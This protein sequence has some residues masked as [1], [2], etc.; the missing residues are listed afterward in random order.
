MP[1]T[2]PT[3]SAQAGVGQQHVRLP[4]PIKDARK[5]AVSLVGLAGAL[6][7]VVFS[8]V[9]RYG[10][11]QLVFSMLMEDVEIGSLRVVAWIVAPVL[12]E[13]AKLS[14]VYA[15][16]LAIGIILAETAT[17][18]LVIQLVTSSRQLR[19]ITVQQRNEVLDAPES[20]IALA[21]WNLRWRI[22]AASVALAALLPVTVGTIC[23]EWHV[24][25]MRCVLNTVQLEQ[26]ADLAGDFSGTVALSYVPRIQEI[27]HPEWFLPAGEA[28]AADYG[29]LPLGIQVSAWGEVLALGLIP[30]LFLALAFHVVR[31]RGEELGRSMRQI[32]SS[33]R[34]QARR[35]WEDTGG[36]DEDDWDDEEYDESEDYAGSELDEEFPGSGHEEHDHTP[37]WECPPGDGADGDEPPISWNDDGT[38]AFCH[39]GSVLK[40]EEVE[41]HKCA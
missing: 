8:V 20:E 12:G 2:T 41:E 21:R 4:T 5:Y 38:L 19:L 29:M 40:P 39:C 26:D 16:V 36:W 14:E 13:T 25:A 33:G 28:M 35:W 7:F 17:F 22:A 9:V 24:A 10:V 11:V 31:E 32:A 3:T 1:E 6:G 15:C 23:L 37:P 30:S 34:E 27:T 18:H